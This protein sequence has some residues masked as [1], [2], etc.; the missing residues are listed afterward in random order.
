VKFHRINGL[1]IRHLYLYKRNAHRLLDVFFWPVIDLVIWGFLSIYL[2]TFN[3]SGINIVTAL[4]GAVIFWSIFQQTKQAVAVS[5]LNDVW[6]RNL[7]NIF[8]S[9]VSV[10]EF[11]VSRIIL[12]FFQIVMVLIVSAAVALILYHF[13]I[14]SFGLSLLP[15]V[16]N[17]ALFG[18]SLGLFAIA[19]IFRLG[20]SAEVLA[21]SLS[22]LFQPF[23]AVFYPVS[24]LPAAVQWVSWLLPSTY[25]FE[26][27]R[28]VIA[29]GVFSAHDFFVALALNIAYL[30]L[31]VALF[32]MMFL[33]VKK[34]GRLLK[35]D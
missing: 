28:Q 14:L 17:L 12:G 3:L 33:S 26:G 15:F 25:V 16:L 24:A 9:P 23:S 31:T 27:M 22:F 6:E 29:T 19:L 4:L 20:S 18:W 2:E 21:F 35:T 1:V 5:F 13:N 11:I 34:T 10:G 8:I 7:L 32:R 30:V